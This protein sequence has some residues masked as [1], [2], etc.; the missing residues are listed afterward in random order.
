MSENGART[1]GQRWPLA[2]IAALAAGVPSTEAA[3]AGGVSSR[4]LCRWRLDPAFVAAVAEYRS[5]ALSRS[6]A[7]LVFAASVAVAALADV[8]QNGPPM[9]RVTAARVIL[10]QVAT[11][12]P[13]PPADALTLDE[14][15]QYVADKMNV[16][17]DEARTAVLEA[18]E[19]LAYQ[20]AR[21]Y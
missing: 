16:T 19:M 8:A 17:V 4:S 14:K 13:L 1:R 2:C 18:Q 10:D 6:R 7:T 9:A 21:R 3:A 5:E 15:A 20:Y 11:L 12:E